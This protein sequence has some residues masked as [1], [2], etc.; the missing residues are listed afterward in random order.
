MVVG[1][2]GVAMTRGTG[3][4]EPAKYARD[5][6]DDQ[7]GCVEKEGTKSGDMKFGGH[8]RRIGSWLGGCDQ[9]SGRRKVSSIDLG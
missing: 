3:G 1:R 4:K 8:G 9:R 7:S 2:I 5:A 6:N